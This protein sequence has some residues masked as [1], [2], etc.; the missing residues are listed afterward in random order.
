MR[1]GKTRTLGNKMPALDVSLDGITI[2]T[3]NTDGFDVMSVNV[4]GTLIDDDPASLHVS[5]GSYP[6]SGASLFL[7]WVPELVLRAG[8]N[9]GVSFL[10]YGATSHPGKTTEELFPNEPPKT[11]T[12]FTP[13]AELFKQLRAKPKVRKS[14]S[15]RLVSSSGT[16]FVGTTAPDEHGFGFTVL[17]NSFHPERARVSLHS[18]TLDSLE[19]RGPM[20]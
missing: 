7:W 1:R 14:F 12:D 17:W 15:F 9:I 6:E 16:S 19:A 20:N 5:G 3:V 18:Y 4:G 8:Q 10:E 2:A 11:Q 13:T